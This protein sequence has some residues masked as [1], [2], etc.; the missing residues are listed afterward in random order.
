M[1]FTVSA[2]RTSRRL[3]AGLRTPSRRDGGGPGQRAPRRV[4]GK[5]NVSSPLPCCSCPPFLRATTPE[6]SP[7]S[8]IPLHGFGQRWVTYRGLPSPLCRRASSLRTVRAA[9]VLGP[10]HA[11]PIWKSAIPQTGKSA[12]R[13]WAPSPSFNHTP[14]R[15]PALRR[16]GHVCRRRTSTAALGALIFPGALRPNSEV[17][18]ARRVAG[19]GAHA[20]GVPFS[21]ARRKPR[22]THFSARRRKF[23]LGHDGLGGSPKPAR[24]P[25]ALLILI[26]EFGLNGEPKAEVCLDL[27]DFP[28]P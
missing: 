22:S 17:G 2:G 13:F 28:T 3:K 19:R 15:R 6:A 16:A 27:A 24:G 12:L 20:A 1:F 23:E 25:R 11:P 26:S 4:L 7:K 14:C 9:N 8:A 18:V 5:E 21:A 10:C